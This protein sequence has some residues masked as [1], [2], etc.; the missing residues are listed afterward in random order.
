MLKVNNTQEFI[1]QGEVL[2]KE[3]A[4]AINYGHHAPIKGKNSNTGAA[5][6]YRA[7]KAA[8]DATR[9]NIRGA[10]EKNRLRL[11]IDGEITLFAVHQ[12]GF[13]YDYDALKACKYL[14]YSLCFPDSTIYVVRM[15]DFINA[16]EFGEITVS[17]T[18]RT[19]QRG[20]YDLK[21]RKTRNLV[22]FFDLNDLT[23][24][25]FFGLTPDEIT[26]YSF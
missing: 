3:T 25:E 16:V 2:K 21:I 1:A 23:T 15:R 9:G 6:L 17:K 7:L 18:E 19:R 8:C 20:H 12:G 26:E 24:E 10:G 22:D 5:N 13:N 11:K 4:Q 14:V